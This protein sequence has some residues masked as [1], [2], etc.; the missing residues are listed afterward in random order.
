VTSS[1]TFH[2]HV[3]ELRNRLFIVFFSVAF[4]S[5]LGYVI[6][7]NILN[8][9]HQPLNSP[10]YYNTPAGAFNL[11]L[12]I[13]V[14]TGIFICI[15]I[16]LY[17]AIRFIQ[18]ALF[19]KISPR[20]ISSILIA[21]SIL[22]VIGA[23]FGF[24]ILLPLSLHFFGGYSSKNI[25]PLLSASEYF[26]YVL[27]I[28]IAFAILFQIPL[29]IDFINRVKPFKPKQLLKYQ[30]YV[31]VGAIIIAIILP[32]TFDP[33]TQFIVAIPIVA[34]Y[35]LSILMVRISN[36]QTRGAKLRSKYSNLEPIANKHQTYI[37]VFNNNDL[38][39]ERVRPSLKANT[40]SIDIAVAKKQPV[41]LN[42]AT[43][44]PNKARFIDGFRPIV[45]NI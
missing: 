33:L 45:G 14:V 41:S 42:K 34:L 39:I 9:I 25:T 7:N 3:K 5:V 40:Q 19:K 23:A 37:P 36:R 6:R 28:I 31:I 8:F 1:E 22:A 2:D 26:N 35:Y 11:S 20:T 15:P 10:L 24:Y 27:N 32:F 30:K 29:I 16:I 38:A 44:A 12:K 17:Q 21:S 43:S 4:F 18:P 13:S